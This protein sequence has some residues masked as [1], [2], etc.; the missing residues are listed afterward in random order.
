MH[1]MQ[2]FIQI[3]VYQNLLLCKPVDI[4]KN[5]KLDVCQKFIGQIAIFIK[6]AW[7][8]WIM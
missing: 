8:P 4:I 7:R 1:C 2:D 5:C 3:Y 6:T